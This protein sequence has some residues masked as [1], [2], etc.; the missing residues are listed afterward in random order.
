MEPLK[1]EISLDEKQLKQILNGEEVTFSGITI[2]DMLE[3]KIV[4][5]KEI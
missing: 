1:F 4:I 3:L 5:K 2:A